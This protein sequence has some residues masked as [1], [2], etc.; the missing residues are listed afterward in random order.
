MRL[1]EALSAGTLA[2]NTLAY[3]DATSAAD[4][5]WL[6][7]HGN[8]AA[9]LLAEVRDAIAYGGAVYVATDGSVRV[10]AGR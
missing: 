5:A 9:Y 6:D 3:P 8:H 1:T 4:G 7:E 10:R 2:L